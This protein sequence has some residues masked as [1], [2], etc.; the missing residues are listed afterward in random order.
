M[1][2][3]QIPRVSLFSLERRSRF[4]CRVSILIRFEKSGL[5]QSLTSFHLT[6]NIPVQLGVSVP[7]AVVKVV[8][9]DMTP[10]MAGMA[11]ASTRE[12]TPFMLWS[13]LPVLT[14]VLSLPLWATI[15]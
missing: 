2:K 14:K 13:M 10:A 9:V 4:I 15:S 5:K 8:L 11:M 1:S 12:A 6:G 3:H 7:Y